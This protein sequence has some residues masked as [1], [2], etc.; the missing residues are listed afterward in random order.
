[1]KVGLLTQIVF[2]GFFGPRIRP[3]LLSDH[4]STK[5]SIRMLSSYRPLEKPPLHPLYLTTILILIR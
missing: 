3:L 2:F 4:Y 5:M 1:M